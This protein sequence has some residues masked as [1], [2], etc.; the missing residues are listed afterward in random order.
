[1]DSQYIYKIIKEKTLDDLEKKA[2]YAYNVG[3]C[4]CGGVTI[5][6]TSEFRYIQ[7]LLIKVEGLETPPSLEF[8]DMV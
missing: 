4:P 1:M 8:G 6:S 3:W 2:S 7:T 5:D